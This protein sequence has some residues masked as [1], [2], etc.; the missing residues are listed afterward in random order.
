MTDQQGPTE[1]EAVAM[2]AGALAIGASAQA[3]AATLSP[4]LGIPVS[5]LL[6]LVL[7]AQSK[8]VT[9]GV[10]TRSPETASAQASALEGTYRAQYVHAASRRAAAGVASGVPRETVLS[11]ERRY[12]NLHLEAM[13]N[14]KR[15]AA[16]VDKAARTYGDELGWYAKMDPRT[17]EECR[18]ANGK[19]FF[20][21]KM[22]SIGYP[23][24]VH[25]YCR[26]KPGR[27]HPTSHTVYGIKVKEHAA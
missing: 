11:N 4:H 17:T 10:A 15:T 21:S 13:A 6:P 16:A 8:P 23:G 24:A 9:Y 25:L 14:R 5:I 1:A 19:N 18:Q 7:L 12:F 3:T 26:C 22:P 2:I 20:A 27:K